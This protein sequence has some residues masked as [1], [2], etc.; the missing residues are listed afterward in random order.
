[1][2]YREGL[3]TR[4][5]LADGCADIVTCCQALHWM[6]PQP[7]YAE[8]ARILRP[9]GVFAACDADFPPTIRW[10]IDAAFAQFHARAEELER[11]LHAADQ[12]H[13]W[14]K[15]GHLKR[16]KESA[17]FRWTKEVLLHHV[18]IGSSERLVG[19]SLSFGAVSALFRKGVTE[20][21]LGLDQ[22]R[23]AARQIL[24]DDPQ[25]WYFSFRVRI[26]VK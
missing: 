2:T 16:M 25:P 10:Q 23:T 6:D 11:Q 4:T 19:L 9:G 17:R 21:Q 13:R 8:I 12:V 22:F 3:S 24:G 26:G 15:S 14:P 5:G 7:T 18:E 20:Q 1:V